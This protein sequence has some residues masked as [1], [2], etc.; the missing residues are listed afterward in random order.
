MH[1]HVQENSNLK[2]LKDKRDIGAF[3]GKDQRISK[4][5][6]CF[7]PI[8]VSFMP[9]PLKIIRSIGVLINESQNR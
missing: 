3:K 5:F 1:F 9:M 6:F 8:S 7:Q 4:R 2:A